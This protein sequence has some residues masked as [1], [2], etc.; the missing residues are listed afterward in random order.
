M[1]TRTLTP[2]TSLFSRFK[3]TKKLEER[4]LGFEDMLHPKQPIRIPDGQHILICGLTGAGKSNLL[5]NLIL[6]QADKAC[7][8][9]S[10]LY[11]IDLKKG[12][13][14]TPYGPLWQQLATN[15]NEAISLLEEINEEL[16]WRCAWLIQNGQRTY[17]NDKPIYLFIDEA[18]EL[19]GAID[20]DARQ[21][22]ERAR[23]LLDRILRQGRAVG[24]TVILATQDPR[25]E[26]SPFRDRC[27][28]RIALRLNSKDE[29]K[30]M[31]GDSAVTDGAAPWLIGHRQ[32]GVGYLY[33]ADRHRIIRFH[34]PYVDD[35]LIHDTASCC[36]RIDTL[37]GTDASGDTS[38]TPETKRAT[39]RMA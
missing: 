20:R 15:L 13:E 9:Q 6:S 39:G 19:T 7:N 23:A 30:M 31:L 5:A 29:T 12:V 14:F 17:A 10:L 4:G 11:G 2:L 37:H 26:V 32:P 16:D 27:P 34:V 38:T 36:Q 18:A 25:K 35:N 21:Q 22:Q 33:D 3:R 28:T 1:T 8:S 24:I